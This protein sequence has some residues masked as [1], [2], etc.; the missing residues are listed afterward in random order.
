VL[1]GTEGPVG[2][3]VASVLPSVFLSEIVLGVLFQLLRL[4]DLSVELFRT[5]VC[6]QPVPGSY[7]PYSP[8]NSKGAALEAL[9]SALLRFGPFAA[10]P[11]AAIGQKVDP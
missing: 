11:V 2:E 6:V 8:E 1:I 9:V 7:C 3:V 5:G 10:S 4:Q